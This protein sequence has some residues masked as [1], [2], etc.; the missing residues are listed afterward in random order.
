MQFDTVAVFSFNNLMYSVTNIILVRVRFHPWSYE[1]V[2]E[3]LLSTCRDLHLSLE[4][5]DIL[6]NLVSCL[7][8]R[9]RSCNMLGIFSFV[10][11]L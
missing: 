4:G 2:A 1:I 5:F 9:G 3:V 10:A 8:A 7:E 11:L 6:R